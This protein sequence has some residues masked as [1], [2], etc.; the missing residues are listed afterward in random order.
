MDSTLYLDQLR[1]YVFEHFDFIRLKDPAP[2]VTLPALVRL[3]W[4]Y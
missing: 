4:R 2:S 1:E 3:V